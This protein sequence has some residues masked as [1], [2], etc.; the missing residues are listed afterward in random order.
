MMFQMLQANS[1]EVKISEIYLHAGLKFLKG[2]YLLECLT[3]PITRPRN[4]LVAFRSYIDAANLF[5]YC[6]GTNEKNGKTEVT[7]LAY[8]CMEVAYLRVAFALQHVCSSSQSTL[9]KGDTGM[10]WNFEPKNNNA[11]H[12]KQLL[13]IS[14]HVTAA[15]DT[16]MRSHCALE[17]AIK[18]H[19]CTDGH[20]TGS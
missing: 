14:V 5:K 12:L 2:A 17:H 20:E 18:H 16:S 8:K 11:S 9:Y 10:S 15:M 4:A 6:A 1:D 7:A 19:S 3:I 13:M